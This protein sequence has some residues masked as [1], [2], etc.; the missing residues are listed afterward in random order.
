MSATTNYRITTSIIASAT[1]HTLLPDTHLSGATDNEAL[2]AALATTIASGY[3]V[4]SA[5]V[6]QAGLI[7]V[8][9]QPKT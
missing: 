9:V 4:S 2:T 8:E 1:S 7:S 5:R 3:S 6:V